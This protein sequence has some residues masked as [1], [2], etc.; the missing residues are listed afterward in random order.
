MFIRN[1]FVNLLIVLVIVIVV[2]VI[3]IECFG[4]VS[5]GSI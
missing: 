3:V 2:I 4:S 1:G 5:F